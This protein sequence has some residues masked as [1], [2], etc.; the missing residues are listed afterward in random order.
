LLSN[1]FTVLSAGETNTSGTNNYRYVAWHTP[2]I[3]VGST[4]TQT[5]SLNVGSTNNYIGAAFTLIGNSSSVNLTSITLSETG[6]VNGNTNLSNVKLYY[7]TAATCAFSGTEPQF[8]TTQSFN[9]SDQAVFTGT[10]PVGS[11][12]IC[13]YPV[14]DVGSGASGG[15]TMELQITASTDIVPAT[16]AI[17]GTFPVLLAGTTTLSSS[18]TAPN[19][20]SSLAQK[21]TGDVTLAIGG[22]TNTTSV[23]F[24]ASATD[25]DASD[26]LQLCVEKK[27]L[28]TAFVNTED[29]CG[30]GVAY[31]GTGV[32]VTDTLTGITDATQYHWQVRVKDAAG[33]YSSWVSYGGN[34]D[35]T[36]GASA[37]FGIDTTAPTGGTVY[38]GASTGVD[39]S[40]NTGSLSTLSANWSGFNS[41]VSGLASY[42]YS[43]G[44]TPGAIDVLGWTGN[45]T[46]TAMTNSGLTLATSTMYY[47][48]VRANDNAGNASI[49]T[50]SGQMVAPSLSFSVSPSALTFNNLNP[51]NSY[52]NTQVA[53]L[54]TSTNAYNGYV[55]RSYVTDFLR[56]SDTLSTVADFS[57]GSYASPAV[58]GAGT[59][60]GYTSSDTNI[61]GSNKFGSATLYAP[62]AHSGPGDI[63]ADNTSVT[64]GTPI[65]NE[66]FNI[67]YQVKTAPTQAAKQYSTTVVYTATAQY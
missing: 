15:Q 39:L 23:K 21:T 35:T 29:T 12:Q 7:E 24:T 41:N 38:D 50:S 10:L 18:N 34:S 17:Y 42:D 14:L 45:G 5:S 48:N 60:F 1:G 16:G 44:T 22:W 4:G 53:T 59:G 66:Q 33:A 9:V 64:T 27:D 31:S 6:T 62:F 67:T 32:T 52:N 19:S 51:G 61:Q 30:T 20:P 8:G 49:V 40:Y 46:T 54:T 56:S 11:S 63:V 2:G 37:D 58:W 36:P 47:I 55:V 43:I 57:G 26:T 3:T 65:T 13:V 25:P 28:N